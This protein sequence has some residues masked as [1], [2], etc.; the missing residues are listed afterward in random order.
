R[1]RPECTSC[2]RGFPANVPWGL[3]REGKALTLGSKGFVAGVPPAGTITESLA[4]FGT[5][6]TGEAAPS[7][8]SVFDASSMA[9]TGGLARNLD[10]LAKQAALT[11]GEAQPE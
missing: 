4:R 1:R 11:R 3:G 10:E 9:P 8:L 2:F 6:W 7:R 5:D